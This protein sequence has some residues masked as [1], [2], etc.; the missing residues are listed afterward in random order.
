[1]SQSF[2]K[3]IR[4]VGEGL[5]TK[6]Y[7]NLYNSAHRWDISKIPTAQD[8]TTACLVIHQFWAH[9]PLWTKITQGKKVIFVWFLNS[10]YVTFVP[11]PITPLA[12]ENHTKHHLLKFCFWRWLLCDFQVIFI[13]YLNSNIT[14]FWWC[15]VLCDFWVIDFVWCLGDVSSWAHVGHCIL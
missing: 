3:K 7:K 2:V 13:Y 8:T 9:F 6:A 12:V 14:Y 11:N 4:K 1:M 15:D 10:G 5:T